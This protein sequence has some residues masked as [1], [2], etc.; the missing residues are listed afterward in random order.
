MLA[1]DLFQFTDLLVKFLFRRLKSVGLG[2]LNPDHGI[3]CL[4]R[5]DCV[6]GFN[7]VLQIC[8]HTVEHL[9]RHNTFAG[10]RDHGYAGSCGSDRVI[11][12]V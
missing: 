5:S 1:V 12:I 3:Q 9:F 2:R 8:G 6:S 7:R 10:F 4:F 11:D